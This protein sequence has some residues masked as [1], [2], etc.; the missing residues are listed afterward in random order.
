[1]N[2]FIEYTTHHPLMVA[3]AALLAIVAIVMEIRQ[4]ALG[5]NVVAPSDAVRLVN[6][7]ALV[8][9]VRDSKDYEA[10]HIIDARHVPTADVAARA[11]SLKKFKDKPV[12][13][14]CESGAASAAGARALQAL[15]F[16]KVVAL[17]GGLSAWRQDNLPLVKGGAKKEGKST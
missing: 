17:R 8:I 3:A 6:S 9:D 1:M 10:G 11:E 13:V 14:Y 2:R 7:G 16:A 15:G 5:S 4:R 12:L